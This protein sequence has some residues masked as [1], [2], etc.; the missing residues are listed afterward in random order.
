MNIKIGNYWDS[1][2]ADEINKEYFVKLQN[3]LYQE[4][5]QNTIY[6]QQEK[7]FDAFKECSFADTKVVILGQDPYHGQ[8]QAHGMAFSVNHGIKIPPSLNNVFKELK[9]DLADTE[10]GFDIPNHGNLV[11]WARQ[12]VLLL[13][14]IL[15]V[16]AGKPK[17]HKNKGW[18][19]FTDFLIF[20]L[21]QRN[22]PTVFLL[23]GNDAHSKAFTIDNPHHLVLTAAHPSPLARGAFFG[24]KHFSKTNEFLIA[25]GIEPIDW[26]L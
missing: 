12:G 3:F 5:A 23:W 16:K 21:N 18:E 25:N 4:Y 10:R 7:I 14:C 24:C 20:K 13:N 17:S 1:I 6:P 2:I 26:S 9:S 8:G 11:S 22:I 19:Q 15:T